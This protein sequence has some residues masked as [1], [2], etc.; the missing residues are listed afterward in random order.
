MSDDPP[1]E[2]SYLPWILATLVLVVGGAKLEAA[3]PLVARVLALAIPVVPVAIAV[4]RV[5][6]GGA[7]L[8]RAAGYVGWLTILAGEACVVGGFFQVSALAGVTPFA[9]VAL[10]PAAL[11]ALGVHTL[12]ARSLGKA[13]FAGY[14][15][16]AGGFA[17]Y[18]ANHAGNDPFASVF[19]AFFIGML[20]GGAGLLTGE[21]LGRLFKK[22][23]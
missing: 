10:Y 1:S 21:L 22:E 19:G 18:V 23:V 12:E 13:R 14:L 2:R 5:E 6:G 16:I 4:K 20:S 9:R 17:W 11:A 7:K 3:R 15:G 8:E